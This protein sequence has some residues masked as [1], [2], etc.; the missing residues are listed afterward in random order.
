VSTRFVPRC[1]LI[2][3]RLFI[4]RS[5]SDILQFTHLHFTI[6]YNPRSVRNESKKAVDEIKD[7][8][9]PSG[10][11]TRK[12]C[13]QR[14]HRN[15]VWTQWMQLNETA[16]LN[17]KLLSAWGRKSRRR[18]KD[19]RPVRIQSLLSASAHIGLHVITT[20]FTKPREDCG[21]WP[22]HF[23]FIIHLAP[24]PICACKGNIC[25][26]NSLDPFTVAQ[27]CKLTSY[28]TD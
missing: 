17:S 27:F 5:D 24:S 2:T 10:R 18:Q 8:I 11:E 3:S 14:R 19:Y 4:N 21:I 1:R 26:W 7:E 6:E 9:K 28:F 13:I 20:A 23:I 22:L 16:R 12:S 25:K 15:N